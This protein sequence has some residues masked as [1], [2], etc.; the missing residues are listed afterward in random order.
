MCEARCLQ[1]TRRKLVCRV[2]KLLRVAIETRVSKDRRSRGNSVGHDPKSTYFVTTGL[3]YVSRTNK[4][5]L[6]ITCRQ[7]D[8]LLRVSLS[9]SLSFSLSLFLSLDQIARNRLTTL[10]KTE[11]REFLK[12]RRE[13][14]AVAIAR[15]SMRSPIV[16]RV[17][18]NRE[19]Q[20]AICR[21]RGFASAERPIREK[22]RRLSL[23]IRELACLL[24]NRV[25]LIA[26]A[27]VT[28]DKERQ[29]DRFRDS[30]P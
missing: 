24:S 26:R 23:S 3:I 14:N 25:T 2:T 13:S 30:A 6:L 5:L 27:F 7:I 18:D 10:E 9:L 21:F 4:M 29:R 20:R 22:T 17:F 1:N 12:K 15:F 16:T 11:I 19:D 28:K 8:R